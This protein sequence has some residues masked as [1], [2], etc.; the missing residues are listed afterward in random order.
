MLFKKRQ[1]LLLLGNYQESKMRFIFNRNN[2]KKEIIII[3]YILA[4]NFS[5]SQQFTDL[6]GDYLSQTP[7]GDTAVVF[8]PGVVS[9]NKPEHS[10]AIFSPDGNE[11]FW[12]ERK[13]KYMRRIDNRWTV[14]Q[15][16]DLFCDSTRIN[17]HP[18]IS[19]DGK[20][21]YLH[22]EGKK[23]SKEGLV[24]QQ[25]TRYNNQ[26][27]WIVEREKQGW[28][29]P[30]SLSPVVNNNYLQAQAS[31]NKNGD[32]YFLSYLNNVDGECGIFMA[33]F[34][35]GKYLSP[36]ALPESINSKAQDWTPFIAPDDSYLIFSSYREGGFGQGDLYI[37]FHDTIQDI[38]SEAINLGKGINTGV[39]ERFPAI[40]PDGKYI[41][42]TR[43]TEENGHDIFWVSAAIIRKLKL[44][45]SNR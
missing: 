18:F 2:M 19:A 21:L 35:N 6:Y 28:S 23:T 5:F 20:Q 33:K 17:D 24:P 3:I 29:V 42:F 27:I 7:P 25:W 37:S 39:Q 14:P 34:R 16:L 38:W 26:D 9:T 32:V 36:V 12:S 40:S 4:H 31:F 11:V 43:W 8:A 30:I 10:A 22:S 13:I 1:P 44:K 41:F 45:Y 15:A